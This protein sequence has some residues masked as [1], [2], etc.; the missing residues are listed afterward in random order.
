MK[1]FEILLVEKLNESTDT[2]QMMDIVINGEKT[3]TSRCEK[4]RLYNVYINN[5]ITLISLSR[6]T[7]NLLIT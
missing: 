1:D 4:L 2:I 3:M 7:S 6:H 5:M